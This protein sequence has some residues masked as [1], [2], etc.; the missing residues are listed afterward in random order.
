MAWG[1]RAMKWRRHHRRPDFY[2]RLAKNK[3]GR[4]FL[5]FSETAKLLRLCIPA[6]SHFKTFF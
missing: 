2:F 3:G 1:R 4:V 6:F 5:I